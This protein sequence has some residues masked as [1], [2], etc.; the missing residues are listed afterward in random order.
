MHCFTTNFQSTEWRENSKFPSDLRNYCWRF[1]HFW[2]PTEWW[3]LWVE[4]WERIRNIGSWSRLQGSHIQVESNNCRDIRPCWCAI[5]NFS[6]GTSCPWYLFVLSLFYSRTWNPRNE[7]IIQWVMCGWNSQTWAQSFINRGLNRYSSYVKGL[8]SQVDQ[9]Y[10]EHNSQW[11][12][13]ARSSNLDNK[14]DDTSNHYI[15]NVEQS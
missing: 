5:T 11:V 14:E 3:H 9:I 10:L 15:T 13:L 1:S 8:S 12:V 2:N 4:K 7:W 6:Q